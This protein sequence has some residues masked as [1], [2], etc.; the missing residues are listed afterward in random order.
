MS[1]ILGISLITKNVIVIF[2]AKD[3]WHDDISVTCWIT[4]DAENNTSHK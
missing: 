3:Q 2:V 4:I 1:E